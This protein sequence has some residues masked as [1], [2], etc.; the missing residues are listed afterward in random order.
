MAIKYNL[1]SADSHLE[2]NPDRWTPRVPAQY[3][4]R[5][6]RRIKLSSGGDGVVVEGRDLYVLGLAI[7]GK[8]YEEHRL[9]GVSY[10]DGPGAG[11]P[12]QRLR[13]QDQDGVDAEILYTS[14]GNLRFWRGIRDD[15]AFRAVVHAYNEWLSE[16]YC[17]VA[18]N[19]LI[20]M[21]LIPMTNIKDAVAELEYC[22]KAGFKGVAL[23]TFPNGRGRPTPE[24][25]RFW[26]TALDLNMP[27]T[28][29]IGLDGQGPALQ[30]ERVPHDASVAGGQ[31]VD[32][33]GTLGRRSNKA[34]GNLF[35]MAFTGV[36]E[37]FPAL[38]I[39]FAETNIG[40]FPY[41]MQ[42]IEDVYKRERH[43]WLSYFGIKPLVRR[44][45]EYIRDHGLWGIVTDR[46]GVLMRQEIGVDKIMWSNDFPH[47]TSDWPHSSDVI[48]RDFE[49]VPEDER[50]M[51]LAGN[52]I[53]YF[54]LG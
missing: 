23:G 5:A 14:A 53:A 42:K 20:A 36:F 15:D 41:T 46:L 35:Q 8:P 18:P 27:L 32:P 33:I 30:Y 4:D 10:D 3:R 49:G 6:P 52:A 31:G 17:S 7:T 38:R 39:Y 50:Y 37:R 16:E 29:H 25:D 24:D 2:I 21:G 48:Q 43:W 11:S 13:E 44:P 45:S 19:R 1:I 51:M 12:E 22:A 34:V 54:H 47:A 28:V 26:A 9:E 40:W